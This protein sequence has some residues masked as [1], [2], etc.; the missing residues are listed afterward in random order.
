MAVKQLI[1]LIQVTPIPVIS[2][3]YKYSIAIDNR[4][5]YAVAEVVFS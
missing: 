3:T 4:F 2:P 1:V 5:N